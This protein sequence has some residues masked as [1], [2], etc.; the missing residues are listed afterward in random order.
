V[1]LVLWLPVTTHCGLEKLPGLEFLEC[2]SDTPGS[3]SCE[4]DGCQTVE[5]GSYKISD[6]SGGIPLPILSLVVFFTPAPEGSALPEFGRL[7]LLSSAP[8][9]LPVRWQFVSRAALPI[10]APSLLS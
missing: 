7:R 8:P 2:T 10:R 4:G 6:N 5:S 9:D 3:S 1:F